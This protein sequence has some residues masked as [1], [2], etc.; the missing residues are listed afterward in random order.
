M[1]NPEKVR[2]DRLRRMAARQG[3]R[4]V[5]NPRRDPR[6][7]DYGTYMLVGP[8]TLPVA[9]FGWVCP[10]APEGATHLDDV[11]TWL[12]SDEPER[13]SRGQGA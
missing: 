10:G 7:T 13:G 8:D 12:T 2:E 5:R 9:D 1:P 4:L 11:E 3:L 6:A